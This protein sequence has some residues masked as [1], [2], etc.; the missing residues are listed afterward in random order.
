MHPLSQGLLENKNFLDSGHHIGSLS[1]PMRS[2][3]LSLRAMPAIERVQ[4][5]P[6]N[7]STKANETRRGFE[8]GM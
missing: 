6:W 7:N 1:E 3:N 4:L 2:S 8:L 5:S